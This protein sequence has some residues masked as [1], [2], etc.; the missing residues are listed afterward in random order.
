MSFER[1][2]I[3]AAVAQGDMKDPAAAGY[4]S[5][6]IY[7]RRLGIG[8]AY[9]AKVTALDRFDARASKELC[10]T[11]LAV[12]HHHADGGQVERVRDGQVVETATIQRDGKVC[13]KGPG[14]AAYAKYELRTVRDG[15]R[16]KGIEVHVKGGEKPGLLGVRRF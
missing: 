6:T 9:I 5:D 14:E 4:L 15:E 2:H 10:M 3:E 8:Y 16:L 11:D 7:A 1:P 13:L 12:L